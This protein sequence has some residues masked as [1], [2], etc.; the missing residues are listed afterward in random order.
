MDICIQGESG[1][2]FRVQGPTSVAP[3]SPR[4]GLISQGQPERG[5]PLSRVAEVES[6]SG[7]FSLTNV[8]ASW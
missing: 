8:L 5:D 7:E 4:G 2:V 6:G 3:R 1:Q